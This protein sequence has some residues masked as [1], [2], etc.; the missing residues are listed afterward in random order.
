MVTRDLTQVF[1]PSTRLDG[2]MR[3]EAVHLLALCEEPL[4]GSKDSSSNQ[5]SVAVGFAFVDAAAGR[6]YVGSIQDDC[7]HSGFRELLTK[8]APQEI[9]YELGALSD[10]MM[11]VLRNHHSPGLLPVVLSALTHEYMEPQMVNKMVK[12]RG[13]FKTVSG[14]GGS[15]GCPLQAFESL[16][17]KNLA[18]SAL[19]ALISHL[20]RLKVD[21]ELLPSG[22]L[23]PYEVYRGALRLD[24]DTIVNLELLENRDDGGRTGEDSSEIGALYL[25][26]NLCV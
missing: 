8:V 7:S 16:L 12:D 11:K 4:H 22:V 21:S 13:Y 23:L 24:G 17:N 14:G 15:R 3:A 6:F 25:W 18:A 1:S 26:R 2:N 9:L 20:V 10:D 5:A 19:G